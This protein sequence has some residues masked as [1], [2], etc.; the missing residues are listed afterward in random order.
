MTNREKHDPTPE[1]NEQ[2]ARFLEYVLKPGKAD[3]RP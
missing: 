2:I 3:D 1:S